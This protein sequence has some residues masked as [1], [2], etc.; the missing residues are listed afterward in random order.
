MIYECQ[1][2]R[3]LWWDLYKEEKNII[4]EKIYHL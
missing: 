4:N 1:R 2:K 3:W